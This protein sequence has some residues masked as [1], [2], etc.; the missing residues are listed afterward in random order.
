MTSTPK[1]VEQRVADA[2]EQQHRNGPQVTARPG[3]KRH[4][5]QLLARVKFLAIEASYARAAARRAAAREALALAERQA[6]ERRLL[7]LPAVG[8][9]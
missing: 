5:R 2:I 8:S 1:T 3:T 4:A 6:A 7:A 9:S